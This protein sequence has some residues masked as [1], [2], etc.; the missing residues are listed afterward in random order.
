MKNCKLLFDTID[1]AIEL[2]I[3]I[4][5][6]PKRE[7][8]REGVKDITEE[9]DSNEERHAGSLKLCPT[10]WTVTASCYDRI[11]Q[12]YALLL[13]AW[14]VCLEEKLDSDIKTCIN[15]C[16]SQMKTFNFFFGLH[17]SKRLFAQTDNLSKTLQSPSLSA[18]AVKVLQVSR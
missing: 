7:T 5:Y 11:L 16:D 1:T 3:H 9:E 14:E 10:R 2:V 8:I 15:G 13:K 6:S 17:L 18:A 4:K 12:N